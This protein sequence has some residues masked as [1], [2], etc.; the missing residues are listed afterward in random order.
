[1]EKLCLRVADYHQYALFWYIDQPSDMIKDN[2]KG[3]GLQDY[4]LALDFRT[5]NFRFCISVLG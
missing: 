4:F 3:Q 5:Q 2:S 1:M